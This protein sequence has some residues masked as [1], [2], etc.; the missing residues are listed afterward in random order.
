PRA[1][2]GLVARC[3]D[4]VAVVGGVDRVEPGGGAA[5]Q[6]LLLHVA[7]WEGHGR[8]RDHHPVALGRRRR[9]LFGDPDVEARRRRRRGGRSRGVAAASV[10]GRA[11]GE[12]QDGDE[13]D[14]G[15]RGGRAPAMDGH[16]S[17]PLSTRQSSDGGSGYWTGVASPTR[18]GSGSGSSAPARATWTRP[19]PVS[20]SRPPRSWTPLSTSSSHS[21]ATVAAITGSIMATMPVVV[22]DRWRRPNTS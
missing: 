16:G 19:T 11:G 12:R 20:T 13:R 5:D 10:G 9:D 22:A 3:G 8:L 14:R 1:V 4:P 18:G 17:L 2:L 15:R 7:L 6:E 21:H